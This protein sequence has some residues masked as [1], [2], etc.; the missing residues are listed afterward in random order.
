M[1]NRILCTMLFTHECACSSLFQTN[2]PMLYHPSPVRST[3]SLVESSVTCNPLVFK[4]RSLEDNR[5]DLSS[6]NPHNSFEHTSSR[7]LRS[8]TRRPNPNS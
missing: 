6:N 5:S 4:S 1:N 3:S 2:A 8:R 7:V